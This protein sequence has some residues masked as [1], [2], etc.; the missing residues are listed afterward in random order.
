MV[1]TVAPSAVTAVTSIGLMVAA[2]SRDAV[3]VT[4]YAFSSIMSN[5]V[6]PV[7]TSALTMLA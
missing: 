7:V 2:G 5:S 4:L 1:V 3:P 6:E